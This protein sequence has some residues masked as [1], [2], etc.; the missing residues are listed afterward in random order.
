MCVIPPGVVPLTEE[1]LWKQATN[2]KS[3]NK[4]FMKEPVNVF[5]FGGQHGNGRACNTLKF[6]KIGYSLYTEFIYP[7]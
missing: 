3:D 7:E 2:K 1:A 4:G 6:F 5:I